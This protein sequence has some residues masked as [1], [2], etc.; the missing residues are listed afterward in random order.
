MKYFLT[1]I[2]GFIGSNLAR[3]LV[4]DGHTVHAIIRNPATNNLKDLPNI[5]FFKGDLNDTEVLKRAMEG[6][7]VVFHLAAHAKPWSKDPSEPRRINVDGAVNVFEAAKASGVKRV[8]FTSS[9]ATMSPSEG[10]LAADEDT[11]RTMP[12]FNDYEVT[13]T[14]AEKK[15]REYCSEKLDIVIVNPTRVFGPG[16]L[17][18]SNS[19]TRMIAG[20]KKGTWRIIPGN[21]SKIGNYVFI[22]DVVHGHLLAA[23]K[24]RAGERYIL[25]GDNLSFDDFFR[26][27][28]KATGKKLRMVHLPLFIMTSAAR[29]MEF[30]NRV[31]GI[32]PLITA[33]FVKKYLNHWSLS[34][35]K[36]IRELGYRVTP[37][38]EGVRKTLEWL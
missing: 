26:V 13:K 4:T 27:L 14:E 21:G 34:S 32:P 9:A 8:V 36:A 23:Q 7:D 11:I 38:E 35:D 37:F 12:L 33:G 29:F 15:A 19:V 31:T 6:C 17:N 28:A 30:Q 16:P 10:R 2:T 3:Q 5:Q 22:D 20:Y 1:G 25:G 18:A 24:G